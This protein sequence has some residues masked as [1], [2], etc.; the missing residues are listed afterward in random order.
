MNFAALSDAIQV[1]EWMDEAECRGADPETFFDKDRIAEALAY[2]EKCPVK[3]ECRQFANQHKTYGVF[4]GRVKL[5]LKPE[6]ELPEDK[7][8]PLPNMD[9]RPLSVRDRKNAQQR[10]RRKRSSTEFE[11][12]TRKKQIYQREWRERL[13]P[14]QK[15]ERLARERQLM[16]ERK[17]DPEYVARRRARRNE[18]EKE[19]KANDPVYAERLRTYSRE[20][21]RQHRAQAKA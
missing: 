4:G 8:P 3:K 12:V 2:C 13:T 5:I 19:R 15:A 10:E 7:L 18:Y 20:Y 21:A 17:K 9:W 6:P 16:A 11:Y 1:P 14:E